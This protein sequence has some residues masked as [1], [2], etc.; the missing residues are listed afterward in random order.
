[1]IRFA[2]S[3]L[4]SSAFTNRFSDTKI[5]TITLFLLFNLIGR[6]A[7]QT[8]PAAGI[9]P[10]SSQIGG[11]YDSVD[12]ATGSIML[13][14][15]V[16]RKNEKIPFSYGLLGSTH[17][18]TYINPNLPN[19]P[20]TWATSNHSPTTFVLLGAESL[21]GTAFTSST[22]TITCGSDTKDTENYA[23]A[24]LD[25]SGVF[26]PLPASIKVDNDHCDPLPVTGVTSDG[27]G[28]TL[29]I[30]ST[31]FTLWD[32]SGR[33]FT[34]G[35]GVTDPDGVKE[36]GSGTYTDSLNTNVL[37]AT[38]NGGSNGASDTY[39]YLGGD[40][41]SSDGITVQ[42]SPYHTKTAFG[43]SGPPAIADIDSG[44][45]PQYFPS[46]HQVK[47]GGSFTISYETTPGYSGQ[48]DSN[49]LSYVTGRIASVTYPSGGSV[50]YGYSGGNNGVNCSSLVVPTLTRTTND[51][52]GNINTETY[53]NSDSSATTINFTVVKTDPAPANNQTVYNFSNGFQTQAAAYQGGCPTS[54][55]G[56]AGG[57]TLLKTVATCYG[58]NGSAPPVPPNCTVPSPGP[59]LPI[60][61]TDVYTSLNGSSSNIVKTTFDTYGNTTSVLAYDFGATT[62]TLQTF[63]SYGQ[64]WN[65]TACSAYPSGTF[66][67]NTPCYSHTQDSSG[68]DLAKTQITYSN[69]GHPTSTQKWTGS[70]WLTSSATYNSNGTVATATDVNG[71]VSTPAYNG[72]DGCDG[73]LPTSVTAGGLTTST[74]WN[75]NGGVVTQTTD[76]NSQPTNYAHNDPFWRTT[77]MTDPLGNVTS[78]SYTP[79]T[80]ESAM[81]FNG[82]ASTTD[83]LLTTDGLGRLIESQTRTAPGATTFDNTIVYGY[84]WNSTGTFT[85]QTIPG[86]TAVTKTQTD[87]LGRPLTITDGGG[88]TVSRT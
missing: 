63:T 52:N 85:T 1:M 59:V 67:Y 71:T 16:R 74:Q 18:Y 40:G 17:A 2:A 15:P 72:T 21:I 61:E 42:Y 68:N 35:V 13:D 6:A 22:R 56:C 51:H 33:T 86:G 82:A 87:A 50:T 47:G 37:T 70:S 83:Q 23:F 55:T 77:S 36:S 9:K 25:T 28:Y 20:L 53:V 11:P 80:F 48:K 32:R 57:G 30:T 19:H 78:Y 45:T 41:S 81:N 73:L 79:T 49:G 44:G 64:S 7:S 75:C 88:G 8:D 5:V 43:C 84:G 31:A 10:F 39:T 14:I 60:T 27:S 66:I 4:P 34:N 24:V 54:T 58:S 46:T 69:T 65:G 26:H 76:A 29:Q 38:Y 12:L 3:S 62:P